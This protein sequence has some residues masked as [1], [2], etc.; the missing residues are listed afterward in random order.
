MTAA[1]GPCTWEPVFVECSEG[2]GCTH[3]EGLD[4][5]AAEAVLTMATHWLWQSTMRHY[6]NCEVTIIPCNRSCSGYGS[7]PPFVPYRSGLGWINVGCNRC[8]ADCSCTFV[9]QIILPT[10]GEIV[11][12][13]VDGVPFDEWRLDSHR[14]LV[15][16]DGGRWPVCQDLAFVDLPEFSITY[17]P[18]YDAPVGGQVA[19][20]TL[21]CQLARRACGAKCDLPANTTAMTRQGVSITLE[22]SQAT[23]LWIVD[24]WVEMVNRAVPKVSSPDL[25]RPRTLTTLT[26]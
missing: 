25:I 15:R 14:L 5:A 9:D 16:T 4:P 18:G 20:G 19:L 3:L 1:P 6:G 21:A 24:Q 7:T 12:V 8:G 26:S 2:G 22:P 23:G 17:I 13:V 10:V 11:G